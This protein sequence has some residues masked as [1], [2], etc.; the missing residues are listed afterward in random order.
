VVEDVAEPQQAA[1]ADEAAAT[2]KLQAPG[3]LCQQR[4]IMNIT[5]ITE[6]TARYMLRLLMAKTLVS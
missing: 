6:R 2:L 4:Y 3:T 1:E 5:E